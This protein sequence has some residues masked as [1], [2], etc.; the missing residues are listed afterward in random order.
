M[1]DKMTLCT[2]FPQYRRSVGVS[3]FLLINGRV[4]LL[5]SKF[6]RY[7]G[8]VVISYSLSS[9]IDKRNMDSI[10]GMPLIYIKHIM[11]ANFGPYIHC[12]DP[13]IDV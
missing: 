5:Y 1:Y 4:G 10:A 13:E 3:D 6:W 9:M 8:T 11:G 2:I 7:F 12:V